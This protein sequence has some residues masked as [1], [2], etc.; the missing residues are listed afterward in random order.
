MLTPPGLASKRPLR[1][2]QD[3]FAS[4]VSSFR[5]V[6]SCLHHETPIGSTCPLNA[7]QC[8]AHLAALRSAPHPVPSHL[9]HHGSS[10]LS[11]VP[12]H[13]SSPVNW[14]VHP[15]RA[16]RLRPPMI[17][18][19]PNIAAGRRP[20][21]FVPSCSVQNAPSPPPS[22]RTS[23]GPPHLVPPAVWLGSPILNSRSNCPS[24]TCF[25]HVTEGTAKKGKKRGT[26][27]GT[28]FRGIA[29]LHNY[30]VV[31]INPPYSG[32][33]TQPRRA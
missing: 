14:S 27:F 29:D 4:P 16:T 6:P 3:R 10:P 23:F 9:D 7:P 8:P 25:D 26:R 20:S 12:R 2:V 21:H 32:E 15:L 22:H 24:A 1:L 28:G 30:A 11:P 13:T 33:V 19:H 17:H 18:S 31:C 5:H